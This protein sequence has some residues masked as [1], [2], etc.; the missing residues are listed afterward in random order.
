MAASYPN[1]TDSW[2]LI[3][4]ASSGLGR[5]FARQLA[6]RGANCV[7][8]ARRKDRLETLADELRTL[9]RQAEVVALDLSEAGAVDRLVAALAER[10]I[11]P[12]VLINNAGFGV[13]GDFAANDWA[14]VQQ[15]LRL[16]MEALTEL[17]YKLLPSLRTHADAYLLQVASLAGFQPCPGYAA[18]AATKAYVL[19]FGE[20]LAHELRSEGI[21]VSVLCPGMTRTE[22][23]EVSGQTRV[24][25]SKHLMMDSEPVVASGLDALF[26]GQPT[27]V[28]GA[29]NATGAFLNRLLPRRVA[30]SAAA[31]MVRRVGEA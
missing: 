28:A 13:H 4:G 12:R 21:H 18:Y 19:S 6:A 5:D 29:L 3:T 23:F 14:K 9:G 16:N 8:V 17:S 22:F 25:Q 1:L 26:R 24:N 2:A 7:L 27:R 15:M 31:S 30:T 11:T 10:A 20:A